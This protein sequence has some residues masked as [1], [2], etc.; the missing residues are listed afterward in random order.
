M[1]EFTPP[2]KLKSLTIRQRK[3]MQMNADLQAK[4]E[5]LWNNQSELGN[6]EWRIV[7]R[8]VLSYLITAQFELPASKWSLESK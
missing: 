3:I 5:Y 6:E 2:L 4:I 8:G 7:V 1:E